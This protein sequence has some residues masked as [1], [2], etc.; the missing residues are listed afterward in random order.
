MRSGTV[1][2]LN[3]VIGV[4][5]SGDGNLHQVLCD[6]GKVRTLKGKL[7]EVCQ[8]HALALLFYTKLIEGMKK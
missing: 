5:Q 2:I 3:D 1:V 8:P 7:T 4:V 6:D